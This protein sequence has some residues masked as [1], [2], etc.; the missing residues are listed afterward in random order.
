MTFYSPEMYCQ[1]VWDLGRS[2]MYFNEWLSET[3]FE[4]CEPKMTRRLYKLI[5]NYLSSFSSEEDEDFDNQEDLFLHFNQQ[6]F[7]KI[8]VLA[9]KIIVQMPQR[10]KVTQHFE[11][12]LQNL[13]A[14]NN[15]LETPQG[16]SKDWIRIHY[17][18]Q[19]M[20]KNQLWTLEELMNNI[21][22]DPPSQPPSQN[23]Q[24]PSPAS[25]PSN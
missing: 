6:V 3:Y 16:Q 2:V 14:L 7:N 1:E 24:P 12:I 21:P 18:Y 5:S 8:V 19:T 4:V 13:R 11:N 20:V 15:Y 25:L 17:E 22:N 9:D 10:E 23:Q